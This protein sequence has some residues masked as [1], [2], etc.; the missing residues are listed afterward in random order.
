MA[1][2][3]IK[4][5]N[6][7][8]FSELEVNL[9]NFNILIGANASGKS[10]FIQIFKFLRDIVRHG[11]ENAI[12]L[13]GDVKYFKNTIIE[14]SREFSLQIVLDQFAGIFARKDK[15]LVGVEPKQLFY[16]F[17]LSFKKRGGGFEISRDHL[18][19]NCEFVELEKIKNG[20]KGKNIL[21]SGEITVSVEDRKIKYQLETPKEALLKEED[22]FLPF[23][24][25]TT[26]PPKMLLLETSFIPFLTPFEKY[27]DNVSIYDFYPRFM[28]KAVP[29]SG[30]KELEE[31]GSN[32]ALVL[33]NIL[34]D[35]D[36]KK[37][38]LNLLQDLLPFVN[39]L[40][41]SKF[42]DRSM[43]FSLRELFCK[44][45]YLPASLLS[46]GTVYITALIIALFFDEKPYEKLPLII[47]EE[48]ERNI[49][50]SLIFKMM[51]M[52]KEASKKKQIILTTH[53]PEVVKHTDLGDLLFIS[54]DEYGFS[55]ITRPGEKHEVKTFLENEI[56][57]EELF[58]QDLLGV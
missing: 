31:D 44:S 42:A 34:D 47:L 7:K 58:I 19:L 9:S 50:P 6:F 22:I 14:P 49:H 46:D 51:Q 4:I 18:I 29:I 55:T 8:S 27:F 26:L 12:S 32:V 48:P 23:F 33:K 2:R 3:K 39:D 45:Q 24:R 16:D 17:T 41:I 15:K 56:G 11:L 13:Q 37:R 20:I 38:F 40:K 10:N 30:I 52:L 36:K 1:I 5:S 35:K 21:G 25:E 53:N 28:K 54:R 57:I 43:H